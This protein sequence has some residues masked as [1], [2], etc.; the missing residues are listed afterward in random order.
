MPEAAFARVC[1]PFNPDRKAILTYDDVCE[2][3]GY[4]HNKPVRDHPQVLSD[5]FQQISRRQPYTE[6]WYKRLIG[7]FWGNKG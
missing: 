7:W 2:L 1:P 6:P 5:W 4:L 3:N